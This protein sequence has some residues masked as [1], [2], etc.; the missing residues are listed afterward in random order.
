[1]RCIFVSD[2]HGEK[3][4]F[5]ALFD[6]IEKERPDGVFLG[7][8][9]LPG[10]FGIT[11]DIKQFIQ[12]EFLSKISKLKQDGIETRFFVILG[13]DDP[14]I[15]ENQLLVAEKEGLIEYMHNRTVS[16]GNLFV[17]GYSYIPPSPF[18]LK[19]WERYD[20]SR[21]VDPGCVSPE[22]GSRSVEVDIQNER[23]RTIAEDLKLLSK[24]FPPEKTIYLFHAPP[25]NT[26]LDR[27]DL[28]GKTIDHVALDVHIGSIAIKQFIDKKK[29]FLTLHGHVHESARITGVWHEKIGLTH[30]FSAAHDGSELVLVRFDT[31]DLDNATRVLI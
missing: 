31:D 14:K 3:S 11:M 7:G 8:D 1:L 4:R 6:I 12:I 23:Y 22:E 24:K 29:P 30:L 21:Y 26:N 9:L 16:F 20:V 5:D 2:L 13:N 18:R 19:D 17:A 10:G 28:D 15:Y 27:A 25:H